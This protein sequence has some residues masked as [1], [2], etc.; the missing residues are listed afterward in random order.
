MTRMYHEIAYMRLEA[1]SE[2]SILFLRQIL[3]VNVT[4]WL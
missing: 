2:T 1:L 3:N 4:C